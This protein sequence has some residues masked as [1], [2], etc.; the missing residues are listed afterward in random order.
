MIVPAIELRGITKYF[1]AL[2]A[3]QQID[4][5]VGRGEIHALVG[6]NGAGK[7]TLMNI[8]YGLV[9][10]DAG[11]VRI[12]GEEVRLRSSLD[13]ISVGLGMV[14]Q[15]FMLFPSLS[16]YENVIYGAEPNVAGFIRRKRAIRQVADLAERFGLGLD[17]RARV[18][19]LPVGLKQR[20]E[21]LKTL[22]RQASILIFDEPT[23]VLTPKERDALFRSLRRLVAEGK[24]ILFITHKLDEVF[25]LADKVSVMRDGKLIST[26]ATNASNPDILA[27]QM[28]GR[29]LPTNI[30]ADVRTGEIVLEVDH[31]QSGLLKPCSFRLHAGEILGIAG[32]SGNGQSEL[33]AALTGLSPSSGSIRLNGDEINQLDIRQRREVGIAYVPEDRGARGLAQVAT[34]ADNLLMGKQY[35]P[36]LSR[37]G[38]LRNAA[39]RRFGSDLIQRYQIKAEHINT[40]VE[41]LSGGNQQKLM[42]ARELQQSSQ[43]LIIEQPTRGVDIGAIEFIHQQL[44]QAR[45]NG[46]AIL[47]VSSELSEILQLA[48]RILVMFAGAVVADLNADE[49]S[50]QQLGLL[51]S[52]GS[53]VRVA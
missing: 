45:A 7:S 13:A 28:V 48:D 20:V 2:A 44:L 6:E 39:I 37:Y 9:A 4:L 49:T 43:L 35:Q 1:G 47:L 41:S 10:S 12:L 14:H 34:V 29:A 8:L 11:T 46:K 31:L 17:V 51:I 50:E 52:K 23:A 24:T 16:V 26:S 30:K 53:D 21:I 22:Y 36:P 15:H 27:Q 18:S 25:T 33:I 40:R 38:W 5:S 3:N 32:V 19:D 42:I